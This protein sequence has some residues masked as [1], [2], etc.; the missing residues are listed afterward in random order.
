MLIDLP[1]QIETER[2]WLR[3]YRAGDG[4][5]YYEVCQR[6]QAHLLPFEAGNPAQSLRSV[7][8]AEI[9]MRSFAVDWMA[10]N[11]FF[12]GAWDK[13]SGAFVCQVYIGVVDWNLPEFE[14]GYWVDIQR[15]GQGYVTEAVRG[16]LGFI[17]DCL[18]AHRV[19]LGCNE[20]NM[21]SQHVAERCGFTR[22]G[23]IRQTRK[24]ILLPDGSYSGDYLYGLLREEYER[25]RG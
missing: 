21:R 5:A 6:N 7:E 22:E 23:H 15:E 9:L 3:P 20:T 11:V 17:F 18:G 12:L 2:L 25:A 24:H 8:E 10:R 14:V 19:R 13:A 1:E 4:A 16:A